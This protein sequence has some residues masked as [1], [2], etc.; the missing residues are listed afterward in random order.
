VPQKSQA[1]VIYVTLCLHELV[2]YSVVPQ[3]EGA[4]GGMTMQVICPKCG[5]IKSEKIN[6]EMAFAH[7]KDEPVYALARPIVCLEC[8]FAECNLQQEPLMKLREIFQYSV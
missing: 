2:N 5:S 3:T 8:G 1:T 7:G 4:A 6:L